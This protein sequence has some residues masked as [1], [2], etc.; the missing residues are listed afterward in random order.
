[1]LYNKCR[2]RGVV[3]LHLPKGDYMYKATPGRNSGI[4][5]WTDFGRIK[6]PKKVAAVTES[7]V[8]SN[9]TSAACTI[10]YDSETMRRRLAAQ[11]PSRRPLMA[12]TATHG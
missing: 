9:A 10:Q 11:T 6:K 12:G 8:A 3:L 2:S 1:M 7:P 5:A 4:I